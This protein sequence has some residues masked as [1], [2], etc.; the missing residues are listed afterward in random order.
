MKWNHLWLLPAAGVAAGLLVRR[1]AAATSA[2][3]PGGGGGYPAVKGKWVD[4]DAPRRIR[5]IAAPI[6]AAMNWPGLGTYLAAISWVESRGN[7]FAGSDSGN[8]ARG[9]FGIRPKSA[10]VEELGL[11]AS[12]LKDERD[13]VALAAW[14]AY[15]CLKY[16]DPGQTVDWLAIRRCWGYPSKTDDVGSDMGFGHLSDGLDKIGVPQEFMY[17]PAFP[18]G[19]QWLG[20]DVALQL[21]RN[22]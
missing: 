4:A 17:A 14:Y 6:E 20:V 13:S 3:L 9:W 18:P 22:A 19:F 12:A 1:K 11:P 15:R 7:A 10:R 8:L 5:I 16:A 2:P 21:A